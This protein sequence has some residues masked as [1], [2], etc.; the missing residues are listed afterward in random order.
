MEKTISDEQYAIHSVDQFSDWMRNTVKS[1]HYAN[2][3]AMC[4]GY[5]RVFDHAKKV[6]FNLVK[7]SKAIDLRKSKV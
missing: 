7:N 4:E 6:R 1:I 3:N 5:D 2:S